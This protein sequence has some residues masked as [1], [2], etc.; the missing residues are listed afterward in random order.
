MPP[1][2]FSSG[3]DE[4]VFSTYATSTGTAH[5]RKLHG[6][7]SLRSTGLASGFATNNIPQPEPK[8]SGPSPRY[9]VQG[10][11]QRDPSEFI[12]PHRVKARA[13]LP[14]RTA[15]E[16]LRVMRAMRATR[17]PS[18]A[19]GSAAFGPRSDIVRQQDKDDPHHTLSVTYPPHALIDEDLPEGAILPHPID[20]MRKAANGSIKNRGHTALWANQHYEPTVSIVRAQSAPARRPGG[21]LRW[22]SNPAGHGGH[23]SLGGHVLVPQSPSSPCPQKRSVLRRVKRLYPEDDPSIPLKPCAAFPPVLPDCP[24]GPGAEAIGSGASKRA[25]LLACTKGGPGPRPAWIID[26]TAHGMA[27]NDEHPVTQPT[28][29]D[30]K[31]ASRL[32]SRRMENEGH[33]PLSIYQSHMINQMLQP[34]PVDGRLNPSRGT[35][36]RNELLCPIGLGLA[37][38]G[39][40][41][42]ARAAPP[43]HPSVARKMEFNDPSNLRTTIS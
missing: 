37:A 10:M 11:Q 36:Y 4:H 2:S 41:N 27:T 38:D 35:G 33:I 22:R 42:A 14:G 43:P 15:K 25:A 30:H 19:M 39:V 26:A 3:G 24:L 31:Q 20:R 16:T 5:D 1:L 21:P 29:L 7:G 6:A 17:I 12:G 28:R 13:Q 40:I 23:R 32:I 9:F 34:E 8:A 18:G